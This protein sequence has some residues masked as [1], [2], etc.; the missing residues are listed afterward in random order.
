MEL[1]LQVVGMKL[2][3]K[4]EDARSVAMRI[5]GTSNADDNTTPQSNGSMQYLSPAVNS[6]R[7]L[8]LTRAANGQGFE[9]LLIDFLS[10]LDLDVESKLSVA[11]AIS[12][13]SPSGQTLLHL[14]AF[15]KFPELAEFLVRRGIDVDMRD[16]NGYTPLHFAAFVKSAECAQVLLQAGAD[17]DIVNV[18]GKTPAELAPPGFLDDLLDGTDDDDD[19][20]AWGDVEDDEDRRPWTKSL[21]TL[22][23]SSLHGPADTDPE[24]KSVVKEK[25]LPFPVDGKNP[26][27]LAIDKMSVSIVDM[28]QRTIAQLQHPQDIIPNVA[29]LPLLQLPDLKQLPGMG[30]VP[31]NALPQM[32]AVFPVLV[33]IPAWSS[34]WSDKRGETGEESPVDEQGTNQ[35]K[36]GGPQ[37]RAIWE[38][39]VQNAAIATGNYREPPPPYQERV[40]DAG[41]VSAVRNDSDAGDEEDEDEGPS[42]HHRPGRT[43]ARRAVYEDTHVPEQEVNAFGYRPLA[44]QNAKLQK[45]RTPVSLQFFLLTDHKIR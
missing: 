1:A 7:P 13:Q 33:P 10:I 17:E 18:L 41:E 29:Q 45:K 44:K 22:H 6:L 40:V 35:R 19:E 5:I 9:R 14:A 21:R 30:A 26:S 37:L 2:N 36:V 11:A 43:Q 20:G 34:L 23:K 15:L 38:K 28:I 39:L 32:P 4:L 31:W 42:V 3:G 16:R 12:H 27:G 25:D 24:E 8:L